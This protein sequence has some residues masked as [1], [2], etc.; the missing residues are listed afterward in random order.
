MPMPSLRAWRFLRELD[1]PPD[2]VPVA[3]LLVLVVVAGLMIGIALTAW[4]SSR[5]HVAQTEVLNLALGTRANMAEYYAV[6]GSW[7]E[8][9]PQIIWPGAGESGG[10]YV[11]TIHVRPGGAVDFVFGSQNAELAGQTLTLR[12][13]QN[14]AG[15]DLPIAW[16]CGRAQRPPLVTNVANATT[17]TTAQLASPCRKH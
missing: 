9:D 17:L 5:V 3:E 4:L 2:W 12:P 8:S 1:E 13:W 7:P 6:H 10:K 11:N 16:L 14:S 15:A